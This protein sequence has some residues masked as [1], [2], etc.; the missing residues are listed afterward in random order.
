MIIAAAS[1]YGNGGG[2]T[3]V[4]N[5]TLRIGGAN[6]LPVGT[7][8]Q[9]GEASKAN[10]GTFDLSG[11]SQ[12]VAG[13]STGGT[14]TSS[15]VINSLATASTL[16]ITYSGSQPET[17]AGRLG[18]GASGNA[19][20]FTVN[21]GG[22][23]ILSG[24]STYAG[25]TTVTRGTL[26][27]NGALTG[28]G[29]VGV[30]PGAVLGGSGTISGP[31]TIAGTIAPGNGSSAQTLK[32]ANPGIAVDLGTNGGTY[33]WSLASTTSTTSAAGNFD[34]IQ[35]TG[36]GSLV[37]GGTSALTLAFLNG[38]DPNSSNPFWQ[39]SESWQIITGAQST[40]TFSTL[41]DGNY[42]A[43]SFNVSNDGAGNQILTFTPSAVP[44]PGSLGLLGIGALGLLAR[45]R[46]HCRRR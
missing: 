16:T 34:T 33:Q 13:L 10:S 37:L 14:G 18:G 2:I 31:A 17:F 39:T 1:T 36:G 15:Q 30:S 38:T 21:G 20:N 32:L 6:F 40:S 43:G 46:R 3:T 27:V 26:L 11:N 42:A 29:A 5:G 35:F 25:A 9:L 28:T 12:S 24:T 4:S 45:R 23:T 7:T 44:E 8:L 41:T 19:F 22:T